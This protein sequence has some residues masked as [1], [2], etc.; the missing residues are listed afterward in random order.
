MQRFDYGQKGLFEDLAA[1]ATRSAGQDREKL[2]RSVAAILE[3]VRS[4]GDEAVASHTARIDGVELKPSQ[5]RLPQSALAEAAAALDSE[6]RAAIKGAKA[7]VR[8]FHER[9]LP[10][11]WTGENPHGATVGERFYPLSRIGLWIPGGQVPLVSTVVMTAVPAKLAEVPSIAA[12]TPPGKDGQLPDKHVLAALHLCGVEEV[13][14]IGGVTAIGAMA[15]GTK[16]IPPVAKIFGPGNAYVAEAKRQVIG[17]VGIDLV[18]GPSEVLI[19]TDFTARADYVAADL[20]AQAEH[21]SG[22]E[23]VYLVHIGDAGFLDQVDAEL[24][25]QTPQRRL[26]DAINKVLE[27][28]YA[29]ITCSNV[30][31]AV[32]ITN[33]LAPEHLELHVESDESMSLLIEQ[34]NTAGAIFCGKET[35]TV[36]GD[37]AAGPNHTLPTS[38]TGRYYSG[39]QV[40][41]FMRRSSITHYTH[42]ALEKA[43][44]IV[45]A[46]S[47]MEQLDGHGESLE[48]RLR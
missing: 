17:E 24:Q 1:F 35:P 16:T 4:H 3:D 10:T 44:P 25:R 18:A 6:T 15:Y 41:D 14:A 8:S 31:Q 38:R 30:A 32:E 37:F 29:A 2:R 13:Y 11:N 39:L 34:I 22:A 40:I 9:G 33:F 45:R 12:F 5:F 46:F 7:S 19:I 21:G 26:R 43:A 28:G 36:L 47:R 20:I 23:K 27:K 48:I 42:A